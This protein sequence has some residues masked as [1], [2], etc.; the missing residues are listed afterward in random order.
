M[1][2]N[3]NGF[4]FVNALFFRT[5]L[6]IRGKTANFLPIRSGRAQPLQVD[7]EVAEFSQ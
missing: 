6:T 7:R 2:K 3:N 1:G 5:T 4:A